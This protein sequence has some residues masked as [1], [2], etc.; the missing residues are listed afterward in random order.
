MGEKVSAPPHYRY[1]HEGFTKR[2]S[3]VVPPLEVLRPG[4]PAYFELTGRSN[5][6][7]LR[8]LSAPEKHVDRFALV[9]FSQR[10]FKFFD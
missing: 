3:R 7:V 6:C 4:K 10:V 9:N 8:K 5:Q 2:A 1:K